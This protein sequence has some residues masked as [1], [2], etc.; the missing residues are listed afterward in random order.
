MKKSILKTGSITQTI[1]LDKE[2]GEVL[3]NNTKRHTYIANSKEEFFLCYSSI[4]GVFMNMEQSE[5]RVFGYLLRYADADKFDVSKKL[6]IEIAKKT[7]LKERTVYTTLP[8]LVEK[9]L[10]YKHEDGLYQLNPRYVFKGSSNDRNS[11]LKTIIEL[12]CKDC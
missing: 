3:E 8:T 12:G 2:T 9:S 5:I 7:N 11:A 6:R 10:L 4:I 1:I